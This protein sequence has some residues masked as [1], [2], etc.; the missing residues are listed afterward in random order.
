MIGWGPGGVWG[1]EGLRLWV[2]GFWGLGIKVGGLEVWIDFR[3]QPKGGGTAG[4]L[5]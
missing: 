3:W 5:F 2:G 1:L 4:G